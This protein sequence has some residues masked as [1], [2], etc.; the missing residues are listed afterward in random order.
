MFV[1]GLQ[2]LGST[3]ASF[4][5]ATGSPA[6]AALSPQSLAI[7]ASSLAIETLK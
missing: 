4:Q 3:S 6:M 1:S 7:T 5:S 2:G